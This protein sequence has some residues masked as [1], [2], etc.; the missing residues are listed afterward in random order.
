MVNPTERFFDELSR[1]RHEP[2]LERITAKVQFNITDRRNVAHWLVE[3][4]EGDIHVSRQDGNGRC[5][6]CAD[7]ALFDG[8]VTGHVNAIAAMLR[9]ALWVDGDRET[10]VLMQRLF[11]GPCSQRRRP[12]TAQGALRGSGS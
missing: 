4:D 2:R 3:I 8:I 5:G 9:G 11:P 12:L 6:V 7:R 10:W 1:R